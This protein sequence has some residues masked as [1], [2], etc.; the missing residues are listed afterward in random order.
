LEA[1]EKD[2]KKYRTAME[3]HRVDM[4]RSPE[5]SEEGARAAKTQESLLK[6]L[7]EQEKDCIATHELK[8][9]VVACGG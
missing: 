6:G 7:N 9:L 1:D 5:D 3:K 8:S 2:I 4:W